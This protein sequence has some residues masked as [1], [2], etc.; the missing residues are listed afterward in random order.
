[1]V[2]IRK[3]RKSDIKGIVHVCY[4]TGYMGEDATG[5]FSD[6][7][8]FG[9]LFSQY[10]PQHEPEHSFVAV[11][12]D[13]IIGY[14]LGS[15]DTIR[16]EKRYI[17][18]MVPKIMFRLFFITT[19]RFFKDFKNLLK[20]GII[21]T[22]YLKLPKNPK[23]MPREE[24]LE[25]YPAHLHIDIL[26]GYQRQ[27]IGT[28]LMQAFERN[29]RKNKVKGIHLG[30]SERNV[31]AI[32]FYRKHGFKIVRIDWGNIWHDAPNVRGI[33]FAKKI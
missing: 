21:A 4:K 25:K 1:M 11:D 17:T 22:K 10:Y 9:Y 31:K 2:I 28:R 27:G 5:H 20:T 30:T 24:I 23:N 6:E 16:Q 18:R 26:D 14:I 29:M 3:V 8:L 13:K 33:T 12:G 15:P 7:K 19:L 32:P